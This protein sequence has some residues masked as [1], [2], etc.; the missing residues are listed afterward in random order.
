MDDNCRLI[1]RGPTEAYAG[2]SDLLEWIDGNFD[3]FGD[4]Y[5]ASIYAGN[6]Y[7]TRNLNHVQHVLQRNWQNYTKGLG[8]KRVELLVGRG[9]ISSEG[10]LWKRQR[11]L[12]QPAFRDNVIAALLPIIVDANRK[13]LNRWLAAA[14]DKT[15]VNITRDL[16]IM[17]LEV[18][19]RSIFGEDYDRVA[20]EFGMLAEESARDLYFAQAF[21]PLRSVIARTAARR[22][23]ENRT[24]RDFLGLFMEARDKATGI[25]MSDSQMVTEIVTLIVAGHETTALTLNWA[26]YL[27][28]QNPEAED[29][30]AAET[31]KLADNHLPDFKTLAGFKYSGQI[32]DEVLR[33]YPPVWLITRRAIRDDRLGDYFL[34]AKTEVYFSPYLIQRWDHLW[35]EPDRFDPGRFDPGRAT[36]RHPLAMHAFSAGP[37]VCIGETLARFEIHLNLLMVS[38]KLRL[39]PTD[40]KPPDLT[41]EVNLRNRHDFVMTPE[42]RTLPARRAPAT[43]LGRA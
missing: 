40:A 23:A 20:P 38:N 29:R 26:W 24:S 36:N 11:R 32:I 15:T 8:I 30:L 34:P 12:I 4:T 3:R 18:V 25:A 31:T 16:S 33:L 22:R 9:L 2:S 1:P 35:Q 19:L 27:L 42:A 43:S 6:A 21:R 13:L 10:E 14:R 17:V 37:R 39:R 7:V 41:F 28:G 5:K